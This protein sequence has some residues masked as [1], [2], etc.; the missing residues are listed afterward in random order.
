MS[1][2]DVRDILK[3]VA[4]DQAGPSSRSGQEREAVPPAETVAPVRPNPALSPVVFT[5]CVRALEFVLV[6]LAGLCAQRGL[7]AG[8]VPLNLGYVAAILGLAALTVLVLQALGAYGIRAFR[9]FFSVGARVVLG[10]SLVMLLAATALF[11]AKL[12]DNYSR[13]WLVSVYGGGLALLLAERLV[14]ALVVSAQMRRGRFD[15]RVAVVGGGEPAEALIRAIEAQSDSGLKVVGLFDDRNDGRSADVVAGYPKLGTV[16]D[17]VTFARRTKVDL[18]VCVVSRGQI[19]LFDLDF[20]FTRVRGF[21]QVSK[22]EWRLDLEAEGL[23]AAATGQ[24]QRRSNVSIEMEALIVLRDV[25]RQQNRLGH[26]IRLIVRPKGRRLEPFL[27]TVVVPT[28][29]RHI[30]K[31]RLAAHEA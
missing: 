3:T 28:H 16:S 8:V 12:G 30:E 14:L 23:E 18:I 15:R 5:G 1:A 7:L 17:L 25:K 21:R 13:L 24:L 9:A 22:I 20:P 2:F 27:E 29:M 11:L 31:H 4:A 10:W 19:V 6:A 26:A